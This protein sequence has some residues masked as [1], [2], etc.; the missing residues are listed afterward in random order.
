MVALSAATLKSGAP[1]ALPPVL[2]AVG[3]LL[4]HPAAVGLQIA[5]AN[6]VSVIPGLQIDYPVGA[7]IDLTIEILGWVADTGS[8][9]SGD[10][11]RPGGYKGRIIWDANG[12]PTTYTVPSPGPPIIAT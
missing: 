9:W 6:A 2:R 3:H 5:D 8:I 12:G 4:H 7:A 1:T 10:I 11:A